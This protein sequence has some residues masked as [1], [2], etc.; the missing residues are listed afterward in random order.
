MVVIEL[1]R[2]AFADIGRFEFDDLDDFP[3][4]AASPNDDVVPRSYLS[5]G[6]SVVTVDLDLSTPAGSLR[7]RAGFKETGHIEPN[8]ESN[9][10]V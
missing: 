8:I 9:G 10:V 7:L 2:T 1:A 4:A 3:P 5:V 6:L